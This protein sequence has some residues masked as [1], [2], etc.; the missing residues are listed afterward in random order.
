MRNTYRPKLR[1]N[2]KLENRKTLEKHLQTGRKLELS[3]FFNTHESS[4]NNSKPNQLVQI[5]VVTVTGL[6]PTTI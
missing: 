3:L 1:H 5:F 2:L 6:E 4:E